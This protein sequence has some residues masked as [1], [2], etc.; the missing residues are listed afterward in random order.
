MRPSTLNLQ[1]HM[2]YDVSKTFLATAWDAWSKNSTAGRNEVVGLDNLK[3]LFAGLKVYPSDGQVENMLK[4][5]ELV[6]KNSSSTSNDET[7]KSGL[8]F[9]EFCVIVS[10]IRKLKYTTTVSSNLDKNEGGKAKKPGER[11]HSDARERNLDQQHQEQQQQQYLID[12]K[13]SIGP[14]VFLGGSCNPTTWR[15]DVAIPALNRLDISFYNPQVSEWTSSLL[16]LEH[17]AK[18]KA[19][20]LLFVLDSQTRSTAGAIEVAHISGRNIK[21]LVLVLFPY[22]PNQNIFNDALSFEEFLDLSRNQILLKQLVRRKGLPIL[23]DMSEALEHVKLILSKQKCR[24]QP[25]NV[26]SR[27]ISVC[28]TYDKVKGESGT[29]RLPECRKALVALGYSPDIVTI[30]VVKHVLM[31][32][33]E[34]RQTTAG[35]VSKKCDGKDKYDNYSVELEEFCMLDS[36]MSVLQQEILE[37][38]CVSPIYGTNLQQPPVYLTDC[39]EWNHCLPVLTLTPMDRKRFNSTGQECVSMVEKL[40][41][42]TCNSE[43]DRLSKHQMDASEKRNQ[44]SLGCDSRNDSPA[45][46]EQCSTLPVRDIYLGGSCWM[47]TNWRQKHVIPKLKQNGLSYYTS[48]LHECVDGMTGSSPDVYD[49]HCSEEKL[50]LDFDLLDASRVLLFVI[51]NETRSLNAMTLAAHYIGMGYDVVLCVQMLT[52]EDSPTKQKLTPAAVKDYNR[53]RAYLVDLANRQAVPVFSEIDQA[54][55]CAI[56]KIK[57]SKTQVH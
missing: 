45:T 26:A 7:R 28:R 51:T 9:G 46:S 5:A 27:L 41:S 42:M 30:N 36:C 12:S 15:A 50:S 24:D 49:T 3:R 52:T 32:Y 55:D 11:R 31:F 48:H 20:V 1:Y 54:L 47:L 35:S 21:H 13:Y 16:D 22:K 33:D 38:G 39:P 34:L 17:R 57:L 18:E 29:V 25:K 4:T 44:S 43:Q 19:K 8:T 6:S 53:G 37:N 23:D 56:K 40:G 2:N 10:D 14:E